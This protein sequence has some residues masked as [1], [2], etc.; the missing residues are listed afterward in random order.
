MKQ[1]PKAPAPKPE[2]TPFERMRQLTR[3]VVAV[4]KSELPN[5]RKPTR[6]QS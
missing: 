3:L 2:P 4:P 1:T 6:K 5:K